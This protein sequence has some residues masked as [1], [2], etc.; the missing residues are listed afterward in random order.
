VADGGYGDQGAAVDGE[1]DVLDDGSGDEADDSANA[2]VTTSED[3]PGDGGAGGDAGDGGDSTT[4]TTDTGTTIPTDTGPGHPCYPLAATGAGDAGRPALNL[5]LKHGRFVVVCHA[6]GGMCRVRGYLRT[7]RR[8]TKQAA[9]HATKAKHRAAHRRP[10][11][12]H[13]AHKLKR[14]RARVVVHLTRRGKRILHRTRRLRVTLVIRAPH[15]RR[16]L[17]VVVRR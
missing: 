16:V 4:D 12:A 8:R 15:T 5:R 1:G 17:R 10:V 7:H 9:R 3:D 13:G 6:R 11:V 14:K 2:F